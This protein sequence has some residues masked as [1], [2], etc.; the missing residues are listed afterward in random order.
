MLGIMNK[1]QGL[2]KV[3]LG[4]RCVNNKRDTIAFASWFEIVKK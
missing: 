4:M 1:R 3:S 2:N